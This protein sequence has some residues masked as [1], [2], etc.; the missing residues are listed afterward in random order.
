[1][2]DCSISGCSWVELPAGKYKIRSNKFMESRCQLELDINWKDMIG[3]PAEGEWQ[4]VAP[5]RILS[6]D[7]ECSGRKGIF[8]EPNKDPVIQIANM[9]IRQG[10]KDPFIRN[11]FTLN[12]CAPIVGADVRCFQKEGELLKVSKIFIN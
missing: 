7:I 4:A 10:E 12:G 8:P 6:Y 3:H 2:V 11:V 5:L 9:V 1:M